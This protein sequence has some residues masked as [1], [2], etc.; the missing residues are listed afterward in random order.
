VILHSCAASPGFQGLTPRLQWHFVA[1]CDGRGGAHLAGHDVP[2][3]LGSRVPRELHAPVAVA[4]GEGHRLPGLV[5]TQQLQLVKGTPHSLDLPLI[6]DLATDGRWAR[7]TGAG[8]GVVQVSQAMRDAWLAFA[9]TG[10]PGTQAL[11]WG[12]YS[13]GRRDTMLFD[14][15]SKA[16]PDPP[17]ET[18]V[19]WDNV[20]NASL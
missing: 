4:T 17:R 1:L 20:A 13:V 3:S 19:F 15:V 12:P 18:R 11:S 14:A 16:S 6:F 5:L 2:V 10:T 8:Q 9:R 7:Y